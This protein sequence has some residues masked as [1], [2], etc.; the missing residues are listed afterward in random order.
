VAVLALLAADAVGA[1]PELE[2]PAEV[3]ST[4]V[5]PTTIADNVMCRGKRRRQSITPTPPRLTPLPLHRKNGTSNIH[6]CI[7][8]RVYWRP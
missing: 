2:H 4:Q 3:S 5:V 6:A 8:V 1:L 7:K